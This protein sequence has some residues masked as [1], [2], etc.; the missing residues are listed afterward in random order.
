MFENCLSI[1]KTEHK[2]R[3]RPDVVMLLSLLKGNAFFSK[4]DY[5]VKLE[6]AS[7]M[8]LQS[9]REGHSVFKQGDVGT[10]FYIVLQGEVDVFVT[11]MG[12]Q[13]K[14]CTYNVGGSFG[15]RAL[16]TSEVKGSKSRSDEVLLCC[17]SKLRLCN[18]GMNKAR[19]A[20]LA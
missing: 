11:H 14:A 8:G 5:E 4:L 12:I 6:L 15:E 3:S 7:V 19:L 17:V 16:L 2:K 9:V 18:N 10:L 1:L 20:P 13:F